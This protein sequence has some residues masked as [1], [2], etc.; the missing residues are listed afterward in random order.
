MSE[1]VAIC[2]DDEDTADIALDR[3]SKLQKQR[4]LTL[5]DAVIVRRTEDGKI[6][7]RQSINLV[8]AGAATGGFWGG[9]IGLLFLNPLVGIAAGASAGAVSGALTDI[10]IDDKFIKDMAGKL[11]PGFSA[12]FV[13]VRK[14]TPDRVLPELKDLGGEIFITSLSKDNEDK[15]RNALEGEMRRRVEAGEPIVDPDLAT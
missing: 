10:G 6:K 4:L 11:E 13:L 5:E 7:L 1:L 8:A 14:V 12:I 15:L 2:F 3:A 9:L